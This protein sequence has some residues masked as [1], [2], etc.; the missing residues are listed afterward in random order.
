M[1]QPR[2]KPPFRA[3]HVGSLIRPQEL[4]EAHTQFNQGKLAREAL[5]RAR[6][7]GDPRRRRDAGAASGFN[8]SPTASCGATIGA[9]GSSRASP[10]SARRE[11]GSSFTFTEYSGDTAPRHAGPGGDGQARAQ[12]DNTADDFAF[13]ARADEA[14]GEG[15]AALAV[16][17]SFLL[18][19]SEPQGLALSRPP[20]FFADVAAIYRAEIADLAALGCTYLQIDEVAIAVLC[21]AKNRDSCDGAARIRISSSTIISRRSTM[22]SAATPRT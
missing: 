18:R 3:D 22:R 9:T 12:E 16:G 2:T 13:A 8:P 15:D 14:D 19:R 1:P 17:Q 5:A 21:D 7:Q 11:V 10:A 6:G 4:R 20:A